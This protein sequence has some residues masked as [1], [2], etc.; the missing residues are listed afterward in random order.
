[1]FIITIFGTLPTVKAFTATAGGVNGYCRF[2]ETQISH[3]L[4][5]G[6]QVLN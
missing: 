5:Y 2:G 3:L 1:M 6:L 4:G